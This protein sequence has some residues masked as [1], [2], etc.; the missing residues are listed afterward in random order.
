M[1]ATWDF[2][3]N[4]ES[5]KKGNVDVADVHR[6]LKGHSMCDGRGPAF[7][8]SDILRAIEESVICGNDELI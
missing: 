2:I 8:E 7:R 6:R 3:I 4:H 1:G 5:F